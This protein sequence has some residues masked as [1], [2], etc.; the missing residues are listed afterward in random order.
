MA[1]A[2]PVSIHSATLGVMD[3]LTYDEQGA[4]RGTLP[5]GYH[6]LER[7]ARI[8]TGRATFERATRALMSWDVHRGASLQITAL[9][10]PPSPLAPRPLR[11]GSAPEISVY[12]GQRDP[13]LA[14]ADTESATSVAVGVTLTGLQPGGCGTNRTGAAAPVTSH[15]RRPPV[16]R[17][18]TPS[19]HLIWLL[20]R[21][22]P[23]KCG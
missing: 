20:G 21:L 23:R 6:H 17:R 1:D 15:Q 16:N 13:G 22:G 7:H 14:A 5:A 2:A 18:T 12:S 11:P 9:R 19:R 4:T 3:D 10:P 8:G